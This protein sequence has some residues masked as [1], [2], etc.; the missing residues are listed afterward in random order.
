MIKQTIQRISR[1]LAL[2]ALAL[3]LLTAPAYAASGE[4]ALWMADEI[5]E[6]S[7]DLAGG[8]AENSDQFTGEVIENSGETTGSAVE[9]GTETT[10]D[11]IETYGEILE[12]TG[13]LYSR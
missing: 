6:S 7:G 11:S 5:V 2:G 10:G 9:Y 12:A 1:P 13:L 3:S 4:S 8:M